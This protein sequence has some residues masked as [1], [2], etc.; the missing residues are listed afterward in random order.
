MVFSS[1][2][3]SFSMENLSIAAY[4]AGI[5]AVYAY[6]ESEILPVDFSILTSAVEDLYPIA[7]YPNPTSKYFY[8]TNSEKGLVEIYNQLGIPVHNLRPDS[9]F[10]RIDVAD[11]SLGAYTVIIHSQNEVKTFKLFIVR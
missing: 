10:F 6:G 11:L 1:L 5:S 7:L 9:D 3:K 2:P 8:I 4:S